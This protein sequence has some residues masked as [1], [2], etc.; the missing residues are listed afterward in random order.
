MARPPPPPTHMDCSGQGASGAYQPAFPYQL[1]QAQQ[2]NAVFNAWHAFQPQHP[3]LNANGAAAAAAAAALGMPYP[4]TYAQQMP[5]YAAH[6]PYAMAFSQPN[7]LSFAQ[8]SARAN[9][10]HY[11]GPAA[12]TGPHTSVGA[13]ASHAPQMQKASKHGRAPHKTS[14]A[15]STATSRSG[16]ATS[17]SA[18]V[19]TVLSDS[20]TDS[21]DQ[22]LQ[23]FD[24]DASFQSSDLPSVGERTGMQKWVV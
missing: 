22:E 7:V 9:S 1:L 13:P 18:R 4:Q 2:S 24:I 8:A 5:Q 11:G 10:A 15:T 17:K 14:A 6:N 20:E 12:T 23:D 16:P 21:S 3:M 19:T